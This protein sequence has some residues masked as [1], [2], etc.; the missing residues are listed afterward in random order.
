MDEFLQLAGLVKYYANQVFVALILR[1]GMVMRLTVKSNGEKQ[2]YY[3]EQ[4][5]CRAHVKC[6]L[7]DG[8]QTFTIELFHDNLYLSL[9]HRVKW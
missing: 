9:I 4:S 7:R 2:S 6:V 8:Y 3:A 1:E 5:F